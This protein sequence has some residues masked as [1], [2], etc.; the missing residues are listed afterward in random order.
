MASQLCVGHGREA[1]KLAESHLQ[2][3]VV[4]AQLLL[5]LFDLCLQILDD[6]VLLVDVLIL[7]RVLFGGFGALESFD[8]LQQ[9]VLLLH[10]VLHLSVVS[11][12]SD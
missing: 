12:D 10:Q 6:L 2:L 1:E 9:E 8:L 4:A 7:E 3:C 11:I 5:Q